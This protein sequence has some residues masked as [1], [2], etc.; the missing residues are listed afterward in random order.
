MKANK[1]IIFFVGGTII[2]ALGGFFGAKMHYEKVYQ[3]YADETIAEM[4]EVLYGAAKDEEEYD[5]EEEESI[6]PVKWTKEKEKEVHERLERNRQGTNYAAIYGKMK[7]KENFERMMKENEETERWVREN[8]ESPEDDDSEAEDPE[9]EINPQHETSK[10]RKPHLISADKAAELPDGVDMVELQYYDFDDIL[11][12]G[13]TEERIAYDEIDKLLGDCLTKY[14]FVNSDEP[15]IYVMN[16]E[17]DTCYEVVRVAA[18]YG[19]T[20]D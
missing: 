8:P 14:G 17:L 6:N 16:E 19:E 13:E 20:H 7:H 10:I 9:P 5:E 18:A 15:V 11:A 2:G 3:Q 1:N 4:K 12:D